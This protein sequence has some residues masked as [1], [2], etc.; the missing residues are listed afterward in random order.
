RLLAAGTAALVTSTSEVL[1]LLGVP[2]EP[3][4]AP[5]PADKSQDGPLDSLNK[6]QSMI[7]DVMNFAQG[8]VPDEISALSGIPIMETLRALSVLQRLGIAE[9]NGTQFRLVSRRS[10]SVKNTVN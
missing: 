2:A 1:E 6:T 10:L 3:A 7:Y 4:E 5:V 9:S 8:H